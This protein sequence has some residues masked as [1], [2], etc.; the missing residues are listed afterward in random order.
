MEGEAAKRRK[1]SNLFQSDSEDE[2]E[3]VL[4]DESNTDNIDWFEEDRNIEND[5][6]TLT[7]DCLE[8]PL[9]RSPDVGSS[10]SN[11]TQNIKKFTT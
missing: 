10:L 7:K 5:K 8:K 2:G 1:A 3:V 4:Q 11:L 9:C 6:L